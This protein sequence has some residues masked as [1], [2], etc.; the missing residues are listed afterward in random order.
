[1]GCYERSLDYSGNQREQ[2]RYLSDIFI[3]KKIVK[4]TLFLLGII[5]CIGINYVLGEMLIGLWLDTGKITDL[6]AF[7]LD[8]ESFKPSFLQCG[9]VVPYALCI[10]FLT[11]IEC[12]FNISYQAASVYVCIYAWQ[13]LLLCSV[14]PVLYKGLRCITKKNVS[15]WITAIS[16]LLY[17]T[18]YG[19]ATYALFKHYP[20]NDVNYSFNLCVNDLRQLASHFGVSYSEINIYIYVI[21]FVLLVLLNLFLAS[22]I[23]FKGFTFKKPTASMGK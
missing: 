7:G 1:M 18:I 5:L 16:S 23:K 22:I 2:V 15:G 17:T 21:G 13:I 12:I 14:I 4:I 9:V 8:A 20:L 3:M 19:F 10:L 6:A 11:I